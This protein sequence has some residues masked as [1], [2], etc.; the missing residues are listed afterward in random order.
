MFVNATHAYACTKRYA[1]R[2]P[3]RDQEVRG[4][5]D[6]ERHGERVP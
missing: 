4:E 6:S 1:A 2:E 3:I 5:R